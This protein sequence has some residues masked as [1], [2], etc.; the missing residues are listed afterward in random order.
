VNVCIL[1]LQKYD[2]KTTICREGSQTL[3]RL[4]DLELAQRGRPVDQGGLTQ[5]IKSMARLPE[6]ESREHTV[7]EHGQW[8]WPALMVDQASSLP[9]DGINPLPTIG[10]SSVPGIVGGV[11]QPDAYWL[12]DNIIFSGY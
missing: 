4:L 10:S 11:D 1:T 3:R 7:D 12:M 2:Y 9:S 6:Q 8:L 5:I